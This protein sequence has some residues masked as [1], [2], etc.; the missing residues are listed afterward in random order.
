MS[1]PH[2]TESGRTAARHSRTPF[3]LPGKLIINVDPRIPETARESAAR[4]VT[5]RLSQRISSAISRNVPFDHRKSRFRCDIARRKPGPAGSYDQPETLRIA[6][7]AK[8][9]FYIGPL[10]RQ[11]LNFTHLEARLFQNTFRFRPEVLGRFPA[12]AESLMVSTRA[13]PRCMLEIG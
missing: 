1:L 8:P 13:V 7:A 2:A 11:N 3:T 10:I 4:G 5:F 9:G 12:E 6:C